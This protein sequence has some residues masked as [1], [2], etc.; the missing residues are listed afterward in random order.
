VNYGHL[1]GLRGELTKAIAVYERALAIDPEY[2]EGYL[3][4]G[5]TW[6]RLGDSDRAIAAYQRAL[7]MRPNHAGLMSNLAAALTTVARFDEAIAMCRRAIEADGCLGAAHNNL[8]NA[9]RRRGQVDESL[10][11]YRKAIE[12]GSDSADACSNLATALKDNGQIDEAIDL[13]RR[14]VSLAPDQA[15]LHSN[16]LLGLHYQPG[17]T[18][19]EIGEEARR[20]NDRHARHLKRPEPLS[21]PNSP[22]PDRRLRIGYVSADYYQS[23]CAH[24]ILPLLASHDRE[25][26]EL[27]CYADVIRPD[28]ITHRMQ[29]LAD[30]WRNVVP[31]SDP[32]LAQ[33][34]QQDQIDVLVDLKVHTERNRLLVFARRPAPVQISWLGYPGTTGLQTIDYRLTDQYLDPPGMD[35][36][37]YSEKC[38]RLPDCFWCYDPLE[39]REVHLNALPALSLQ[40]FTFGCL[41]SFCKINDAVIS[42][43]ARILK[44]VPASRLLLLADAGGHRQTTGRRFAELG[45]DASRIEFIPRGAR[46]HYMLAY[47]RIDLG[48]DCFPYNG[49]TTSFDSMWMGVPLITMPGET[50]VSRAGWS[51]LNNIGLAELCAGSP[52]LYVQLGVSW[53][54]DREKLSKLRGELRGRMERSALMDARRFAANVEA[55]YRV[56]WGE[57]CG[58]RR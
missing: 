44:E 23:V 58:R 13:Y 5:N 38:Y 46:R 17:T 20:W 19:R 51:Q 34:I 47:H 11:A 3:Q 8:G 50:A 28:A 53:A 6:Q 15:D 30:H 32:Q 26:F 27:F 22:G 55:A 45:V 37:V 9:L 40:H 1:L 35:E 43:W 24:F 54:K 31:L 39:E 33:Q 29:P 2:F 36:S 25:R 10:T 14:A 49:H 16:L 42:L 41:N 56:A 52:E 21:Y 12:L 4:L 7:G 18:A 48:L 57:W